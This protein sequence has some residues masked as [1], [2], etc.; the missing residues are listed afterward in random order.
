MK[1]P[2]S[3]PPCSTYAATNDSLTDSKSKKT[4][5]RLSFHSK[6]SFSCNEGTRRA[7]GHGA[8]KSRRKKALLL[9][10]AICGAYGGNRDTQP[11]FRAMEWAFLKR[12]PERP[13]ASVL[14]FEGLA[15]DDAKGDPTLL[16][17]LRCSWKKGFEQYAVPSH[18][19]PR[20]GDDQPHLRAAPH[21][22]RPIC[23][24]L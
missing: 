15:T 2:L 6:R 23:N 7:L 11:R 16:R 21:T 19:S 5:N 1:F 17:G 14:Y 18:S 10:S 12:G 13:S 24:A 22:E 9:R 8:Q 20:C 3:S 4:R